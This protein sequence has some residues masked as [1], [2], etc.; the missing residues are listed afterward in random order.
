MGRPRKWPPAIYPHKPSGRDRIRV[1][2][3]DYWLGPSGSEESKREYAR[4]VQELAET[5]QAEKK[6]H[7][8]P[9]L[10]ELISRWDADRAPG[11]S[12][13]EMLHT[14]SALLVLVRGRVSLRTDAVTLAVLRE[15]RKDMLDR[16]QKRHFAGD[17][18]NKTGWSRNYV[19]AQVRRIRTVWR[20]AEE[21]GLAPPGS[22]NHL[23]VLK[24]LPAHDQSL[25]HTERIRPATAEHVEAI[26]LHVRSPA[27]RAMVRLQWLTGMRSGEVRTM[28]VG[29]VDT[30]GAVW[31]YRPRCH[32]NSWRGHD[33]VVTIGPQ[34]Q[35]ILRLFLAGKPANAR[36]FQTRNGKPYTTEVYG[37]IVKR[38]GVRAGLAWVRAYCLRHGAK[39]RIAAE[40][41]LDVARSVLGQ[42]S[43]GT[44]NEYGQAVDLD[45]AIRAA[46][47][48]G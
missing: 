1:D 2:G 45:Q 48:L 23:R 37:T 42:K 6:Q 13:K 3:I 11:M 33:R 32:K 44:T 40:L 14:R 41:G 5:G 20:W 10:V 9:T 16:K 35:D 19:N 18:R 46:E 24:P 36:A 47:K 4:L 27:A 7:A 26:L 43:I 29:E 22:W 25:R 39:Q 12:E 8:F 34:G 15:A 31:L 21:A 17:E 30:T 38:A 28:R